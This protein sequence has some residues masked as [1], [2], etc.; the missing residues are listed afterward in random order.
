MKALFHI[1][2]ILT[3]L[4]ILQ[5]LRYKFGAHPESIEIFTQLG[6]HPITKLIAFGGEPYGR[7]IVGSMELIVGILLLVPKTALWGGLAAVGLMGGAFLSHFLVLGFDSL[8]VMAV[9]TALLGTLT[10]FSSY[11]LKK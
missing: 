3:A 7:Y 8:F 11:K 5:T 9:I 2:R 6:S 10:V 1:S 4:L